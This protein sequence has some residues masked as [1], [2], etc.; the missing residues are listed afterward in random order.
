VNK[1]HLASA[2]AATAMIL[3]GAGQAAA[4]TFING[5]FDFSGKGDYTVVGD[6]G[7][8]ATKLDFGPYTSLHGGGN[9]SGPGN[10]GTDGTF[11]VGT[12]TGSFLAYGLPGMIGSISDFSSLTPGTGGLAT[13]VHSSPLLTVGGFAFDSAA[14]YITDRQATGM[15]LNGTGTITGNGFDPTAGTFILN[16][17]SPESG[18]GSFKFT[19]ASAV[20]AVPEPDTWTLMFVGF[21]M[22]GFVM[23]RRATKETQV[24]F[25]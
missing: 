4:A 9:D 13:P 5:S 11:L 20:S 18:T 15:V 21:G 1:L 23:R 17:V 6:T 24:C 10:F 8:T 22:I 14:I 16:I 25:G 7:L 19:F 2:L 3:I 12:A